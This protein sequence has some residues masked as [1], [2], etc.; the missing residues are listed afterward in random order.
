MKPILNGQYANAR[1]VRA[2][3]QEVVALRS[4]VESHAN[5]L[6]DLRQMLAPIPVDVMVREEIMGR[7]GDGTVRLVSG[8]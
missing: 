7:G 6:A 8:I 3:Q 4:A 1:Q 5:V 2:L